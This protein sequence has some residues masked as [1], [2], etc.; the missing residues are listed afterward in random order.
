MMKEDSTKYM[1]SP[2]PG[3]YAEIERLY[4]I[5]ESSAEQIDQLKQEVVKCRQSIQILQVSPEGT[6]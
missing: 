5:V 4:K 6:L 3:V 1:N 2:T